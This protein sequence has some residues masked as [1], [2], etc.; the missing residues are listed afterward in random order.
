M[1]NDYLYSLLLSSLDALILIVANDCTFGD[2]ISDL[3][4]WDM[5]ALSKIWGLIFRF[6]AF[7]TP[8]SISLISVSSDPSPLTLNQVSLGLGDPSV[9]EHVKN[10]ICPSRRASFSGRPL[11][12]GSLG[13]STMKMMLNMYITPWKGLEIYLDCRLLNSPFFYK[14]YN[15]GYNVSDYGIKTDE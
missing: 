3:F 2:D 10:T 12:T 1:N 7:E 8:S 14:A 13:G 15:S 5:A 9:D 6:W 11:I 4:I